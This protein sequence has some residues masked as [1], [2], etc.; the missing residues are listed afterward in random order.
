MLLKLRLRFADRPDHELAFESDDEDVDAWTMLR[1]RADGDGR[2]ALG[3]RDSCRIEDVVEVSLV[4][5]GPVE[6]PGWRRGLQD[7]DVA[8]AVQENYEPPRP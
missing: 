1:S 2:I 4:E 7:E 3:D 6:G 8:T 5:P